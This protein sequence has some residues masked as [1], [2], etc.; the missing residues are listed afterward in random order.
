MRLVSWNIRRNPDCIDVAFGE[1]GADV[2]L[3]QECNVFSHSRLSALGEG[4]DERWVKHNWGNVVFSK[5]PIE[6][7]E[8]DSE[9]QGSLTIAKVS[10]DRLN[11]A[12]I[13][14]YGLFERIGPNSRKK[15]ATPGLHRKLSDLSPILWKRVDIDV[16]GF[17]LAGDLNHDRRMDSH[18]TFKK[19]DSNPHSGLFERIEDF[20]LTDLLVKKY[21]DGVQTYKS[22]RGDFPWQ[23]DHAFVSNGLAS[24]ANAF[25]SEIGLTQGLSDHNPVIVDLE[26][27][28]GN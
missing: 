14:A 23:L 11:L 15:M 21:P 7:I 27:G 3:A 26:I 6:K 19:K 17:L 10:H 25:V 20:Q 28:L 18:K 8:I 9:Y 24:T 12:V 13:N 2:L 5:L 1:L 16:H 4:I 22:V